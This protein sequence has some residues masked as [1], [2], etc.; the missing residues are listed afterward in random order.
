MNRSTL[1]SRFNAGVLSAAMLAA[2]AGLPAYAQPEDSAVEKQLEGSFDQPL[3][4]GESQGGAQS[5]TVIQSS[6]GKDSYKLE[7]S[8]GK[9]KVWH[10]DKAVPKDRIRKSKDKVELLDKEGGVIHTFKIGGGAG[11]MEVPGFFFREGGQGGGQGGQPGAQSG[12][13]RG[14]QAGG[15]GGAGQPPVPPQPPVDVLIQNAPPVMLGITMSDADEGTLDELN[16]GRGD[17][18]E[19]GIVVDRVVEDLPA[20]RA[21]IEEGDIIVAVGGDHVVGQ[22]QLREMLRGCKPGQEL[23][24]SLVRDGK[25]R[26]F[27]VKLEKFDPTKLNPGGMGVEGGKIEIEGLPNWMQRFGGEQQPGQM[28]EARKAIEQALKQMKENPDLQ[29]EKIRGE[30]QKALEQALKS[31]RDAEKSGQ[32]Q[33]QM[34]PDNQTWVWSGKPDQF[35]TI[36]TP[37]PRADGDTSRKL[38]RL[39]D[40]LE[41]LNRRLDE[42]ERRLDQR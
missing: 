2:A 30:T 39:A 3:K 25:S 26:D 29:P 6:D 4:E 31:F 34:G 20:D 32:W 38:D 11:G 1:F 13:K 41:R 24:L 17:K 14:G 5:R 33:R 23:H 18:I 28:D 40:Q 27:K 16:E 10:N 37:A 8:D 19:H 36:P 15:W 22:E 35:Y 12:G 42:L 7:M 21:G 9:V